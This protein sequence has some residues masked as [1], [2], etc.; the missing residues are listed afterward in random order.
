MLP[1]NPILPSRESHPAR[2]NELAARV[3]DTQ[4]TK[5][6]Q[7]A[8]LQEI[9]QLL[10]ALQQEPAEHDTAWYRLQWQL[11]R[12]ARERAEAELEEAE[13]K[14][15]DAE[16]RIIWLQNQ[17]DQLNEQFEA[18]IARTN[19]MA[20][21]AENANVSKSVFLA[22]MSHE[23]RTPMNAV[24]GMCA[25]LEVSP[26]NAEQLDFV[27]TIRHGSETLLEVIND[28]LDFS[29]IEA[30]KLDIE[31]IQVDM[32]ELLQET[33]NLL[34]V[35]AEE[36]KLQLRL[37]M[38]EGMPRLY[39][40]DPTRLRQILINLLGNAIKFTTHG[41][42]ALRVAVGAREDEQIFLRFEVQ[43]TG[44]G[45]PEDRV[46]Q[47]FRPFSQVDASTT[48]RFGGTGLGLAISARLCELMG[49][50]MGV[51]SI[52]G[53]GSTFHFTLPLPVIGGEVITLAGKELSAANRAAPTD[54]FSDRPEG[55][56]KLRM[57]LAEDN[58]VNRKVLL[59]LLKKMGCTADVAQNGR[60]AFEACMRQPY[61]VVFM[62]VHMPELDGFEATQQI[63][64]YVSPAQQPF[65]IALTAAASR[66]DEERCLEVGMDCYLSKP[67]KVPKLKGAIAEA[68]A[69]IER[70]S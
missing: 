4:A 70:L 30:G 69:S 31:A 53:Q 26:L 27:R 8:R 12:A 33:M 57:L 45:I 9:R 29:K 48:R 1:T 13:A 42:V 63:R 40:G 62:D 19:E 6:I 2:A 14:L 11:E 43:D 22:N 59:L 52:F 21:E 64:Q 41:H 60:E 28:I 50:K 16:R 35:K 46:S 58:A 47:L 15:G 54:D 24:L 38:E 39:Q 18:T 44:I 7:A 65:I 49:G 68:L 36:K 23:I 34:R 37:E 66:L 67:V 3:P 5:R 17:L 25:L 55:M 32:Q 56:E 20:L 10:D 61:D 51:N